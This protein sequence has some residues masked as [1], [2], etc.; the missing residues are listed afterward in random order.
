MS[1]PCSLDAEFATQMTANQVERL[2]ESDPAIFRKRPKRSFPVGLIGK[3]TVA[4]DIHGADRGSSSAN[5]CGA[6]LPSLD[7]KALGQVAVERPASHGDDEIWCDC[8][9]RLSEL[10]AGRLRDG[11]AMHQLGNGLRRRQFALCK[12]ERRRQFRKG[13]RKGGRSQVRKTGQNEFKNA[14]TTPDS[15]R[16]HMCV[17]TANPVV[18]Q[19]RMRVRLRASPEDASPQ[20]FVRNEFSTSTNRLIGDQL[21]VA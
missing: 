17:L 8:D 16:K 21:R 6:E 12:D 11:A 15:I 13:G 10:K 18:A 14:F 7:F 20:S 2:D 19:W 4:V 9:T 5:R 3:R 1:D